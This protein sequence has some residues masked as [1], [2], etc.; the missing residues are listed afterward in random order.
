MNPTKPAVKAS[1]SVENLQKI[2]RLIGLHGI[3]S[4][5]KESKRIIRWILWMEFGWKCIHYHVEKIISWQY[6]AML[7][8]NLQLRTTGL[9]HASLNQ[10]VSQ[11]HPKDG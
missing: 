10:Y 1:V 8:G 11:H 6:L 2:I 5:Q 4:F 7:K 3:K 9:S